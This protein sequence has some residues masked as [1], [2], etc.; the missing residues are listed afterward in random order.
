[1]PTLKSLLGEDAAPVKSP[2]STGDPYLATATIQIDPAD[3]AA[4]IVER[5]RQ[6]A[7]E[8]TPPAADI[9]VVEVEDQHE[10]GDA[11][12]SAPAVEPE[13]A[14]EPDDARLA[15]VLGEFVETISGQIRE[16]IGS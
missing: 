11:A 5:L 7:A 1:M 2:P 4:Q 10:D 8:A 14:P 16:T 3:L 15:E 9:D 12:T 6:P 13:E